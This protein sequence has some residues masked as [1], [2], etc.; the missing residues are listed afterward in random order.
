VKPQGDFTR[1]SSRLE[2]AP[3]KLNLG[4]KV[5]GR[6]ADG[7]HLIESLFVPLDLADE[8]SVE[9]APAERPRVRLESTLAEDALGVP[10]VL[11]SGSENLA[12]RAAEAFLRAAGLSYSVSVKLL[13][14]IPVAAGLGG[15]SSDAGAV[16]RALDALV[17]GAL[18]R[19]QLAEVALALGAD[20]PFFLSARPALVE[21]IG[22]RVTP[23]GGLPP[24]CLVLANPGEGLSTARVF[25]AL[26]SRLD[27]LTRAESGST[28]RSL[29]DWMAVDPGD[30]AVRARR[31]AELLENDLE[32][33]A[34]RLCPEIGQ[35][36]A[37]LME[38]GAQVVGMSG[39]GATSFGVFATPSEAKSAIRNMT[40]RGEG[41]ARLAG[42]LPA[43]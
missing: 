38:M 4:L 41:W 39:S 13:K 7:Y 20:V 25:G 16:L 27:T 33:A 30:L 12:Q 24:L 36:Q 11:P 29:S 21:G 9:I 26:A 2:S 35:I 8:L 22:E 31:L 42:T 32:D 37:R 19:R 18:S 43:R 3:A 17:P 14:R 10:A 1:A 23:I 6:R 15:G 5:V 34:R 40:L 28:L